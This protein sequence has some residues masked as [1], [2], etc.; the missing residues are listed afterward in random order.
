MQQNYYTAVTAFVCIFALVVGTGF[1]GSAVL[2]LFAGYLFGVFEGGMYALIGSIVGATISFLL[3]RYV[4]RGTVTAW[5]GKRIKQFKTQMSTHGVSYLLM[6]HFVTVVPYFVINALAALS[7]ISLLTF[8]WTTIV[9]SMP[10]ISVY[11]FAGR[12]LSYIQSLGDIF[13]PTIILAFVLL[14][15]LACMPIILRK[16]KNI[17][18]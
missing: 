1:P 18:M 17:E 3:F 15:A 12:Q 6:L 5:Y 16:L 9:G 8:V 14:I 10:I 7:D 11:A 4:F 2:T 13:S